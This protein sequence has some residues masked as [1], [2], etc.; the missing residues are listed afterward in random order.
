M[1]AM[2]SVLPKYKACASAGASFIGTLLNDSTM[3]CSLRPE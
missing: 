1:I 2:Y 3:P